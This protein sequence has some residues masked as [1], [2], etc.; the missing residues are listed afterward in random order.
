MNASQPKTV[1]FGMLIPQLKHRQMWEY[2]VG[3]RRGCRDVASATFACLQ[4]P[5]D[6]PSIGA[7]IVP[8]D[9]VA[10]AVDP[11]VPSVQGVVTGAIDAFLQAGAGS[12]DIVVSDEAKPDVFSALQNLS[13]DRIRISQHRSAQRECLRYLGADQSANPIYLNRALVDADFILPIAVS[14]PLDRTPDNDLTGIFPAFADSGAR[15]RHLQRSARQQDNSDGNGMQSEQPSWL[16]GVQIM[17]SVSSNQDGAIGLVLAGTPDAIAK[18]LMPARR[19]PDEFPPSASLVIASL[20]GEAQQQSWLN[21]ARAAAAATR[22][23]L[24]GGTIV[25]WSEIDESLA[26]GTSRFEEIVSGQSFDAPA[27]LDSDSP[28]E[29]Q[30]DS[31]Q[32]FPE[33]QSEQVALWTLTRI[34]AEHRLIIHCRLDSEELEA[35]G[36]AAIESMPQLVKLC[37]SFDS[38]GVLRAAQF[39]G[40]TSE[41]VD[42]V[43]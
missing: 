32:P 10:L 15:L 14:R 28:L 25:L 29:P 40:A 42:R 12:I 36:Y 17:V 39:A 21:A 20:D 35:L 34:A 13:G 41:Q 3:P 4:E 11:N 5:L 2:E 33:W 38:V 24:P 37:E 7:A 9:R 23:L 6:F 18:H 22:Y 43:A 31:E 16:L 27:P 30:E 19:L 26:A 1:D 8:G